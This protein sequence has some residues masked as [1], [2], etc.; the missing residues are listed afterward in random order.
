MER[1][2]NGWECQGT[3]TDESFVLL[4]RGAGAILFCISPRMAHVTKGFSDF[5]VF[6]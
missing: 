3:G 4:E 5:W 2:W 1:K 6:F